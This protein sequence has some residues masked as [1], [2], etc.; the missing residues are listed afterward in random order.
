M[1]ALLQPLVSSALGVLR[2]VPVWAWALAACLAWGGWQRHRAEASTRAAAQAEQSA[3]VAAATA[4]AQAEARAREHEITTRAQEAADAYRSHMA[5]A[6][7]AA[8]SARGERE[9]L[10]DATA[11][12][13]RA[14]RTAPTASAPGGVDGAAEFRVVVRE[15]AAALHQVA[16]AADA[17]D[18]KLTGLQSYV[19]AIGAAPSA[20]ATGDAR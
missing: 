15:C 3:S 8:D 19:R 18:A 10:L 17:G 20:P 2:V 7:R 16:E 11:G 5:A 1:I 6:R 13:G 12:A 4:A 14:C 9:R